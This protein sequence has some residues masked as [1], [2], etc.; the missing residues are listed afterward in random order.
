LFTASPSTFIGGMISTLKG[1]NI[2]QG[3]VSP[4]PQLTAEAVIA[5][6]PEVILLANARHG[7]APEQ[8]KARPGWAG[9]PAVKDN[10]LHPIDPDL[11]N[12]PGPRVVE[13]LELMAR[14]LY[15]ERFR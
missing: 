1:R 13:G 12:R 14:L 11:V 10:R 15:P 3:A 7:G 9:I 6:A 4:F 8:V 2:A 5:A